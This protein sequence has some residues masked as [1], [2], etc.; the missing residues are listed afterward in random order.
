MRRQ[1]S[2]LS[3]QELEQ[4]GSPPSQSA[5]PRGTLSLKHT[6]IDGEHP[7]HGRS[8][9]TTST[10]LALVSH[11]QP[12]YELPPEKFEAVR[13]SKKA[14]GHWL[15]SSICSHESYPHPKHLAIAIIMHIMDNTQAHAQP[16]AHAHAHALHL[17]VQRVQ[18]LL[19][20]VQVTAELRDAIR[21]LSQGTPLVQVLSADRAPRLMAVCCAYLSE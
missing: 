9:V 21:A 1:P 13:A 20:F 2:R 17:R 14:G 6:K 10:Q 15:G 18:R 19:L 5:G 3:L 8:S 11:P 4:A 7:T 12:L 16:G